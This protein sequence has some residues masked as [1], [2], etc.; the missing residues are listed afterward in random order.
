MIQAKNIDSHS[1]ECSNGVLNVSARINDAEYPTTG[2]ASL[3]TFTNSYNTAGE[4][5]FGGT[6]TLNGHIL[7]QNM[8]AFELY[9]MTSDP[10]N[11][12]LLDTAFNK[13]DGTYTFKPVKYTLN[14]V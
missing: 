9:D 11:G 4:I 3:L 2:D 5:T 7:D 12:T 1:G 14:D 13:A 6:K 10:I 8:F